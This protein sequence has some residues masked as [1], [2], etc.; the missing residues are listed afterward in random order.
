M[1]LD[2]GLSLEGLLQAGMMMEN[3]KV[4]IYYWLIYFFTGGLQT[5]AIYMQD[6]EIIKI[7]MVV[8]IKC[9]LYAKCCLLYLLS[10]L[11][12]LTLY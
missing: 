9:S 11:Y 7:T 10:S 8:T 6:R 2:I 4:K 1:I 3:S 5:A 12:H